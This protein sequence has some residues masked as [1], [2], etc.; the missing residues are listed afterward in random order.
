MMMDYYAANTNHKRTRHFEGTDHVLLPGSWRSV[1]AHPSTFSS[2]CFIDEVASKLSRDPI[3]LREQWLSQHFQNH[4]L[5]SEQDAKTINRIKLLKS[6]LGYIK[7]FSNWHNPLEKHKG[8]GVSLSYFYG[9]Y[10]SQVAYV[11]YHN[12]KVTIDRIICVIDCG[13]VINPQ[14]VEA[15][16]EGSIIWSLSALLNPSISIAKGEVIQSNF[17]DYSVAKTNDIPEIKIHILPSERAPNRVGEAAVPDTAPAVLN[18]IYNACDI[19]ITE[20]PIPAD[21]L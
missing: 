9:T 2:E 5:K 13:L 10:V 6:V 20:L 14:L 12:K 7:K 11:S 4:D 3:A 16:I 19:R 18:A 17:H 21:M 1:D 8:K 15:Q